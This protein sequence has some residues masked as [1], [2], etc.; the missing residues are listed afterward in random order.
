MALEHLSYFLDLSLPNLFLF[1]EQK[2]VKKGRFMITDE[3]AAKVMRA[4]SEVLENSFHEYFQKLNEANMSLP[5]GTT[6]KEMCK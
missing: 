4:L 3:V 6:L 5:K 1:P 2:R